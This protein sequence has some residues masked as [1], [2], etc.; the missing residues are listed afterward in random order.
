MGS[1]ETPVL[2]SKPVK[3]RW[4][5]TLKDS[6]GLGCVP[7]SLVKRKGHFATDSCLLGRAGAQKGKHQRSFLIRGCREQM[8]SP[9]PPGTALLTDVLCLLD[10]LRSSEHPVFQP[11]HLGSIIN[12]GL[13]L[14]CI[15]SF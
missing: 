13:D 14:I 9:G 7:S 15:Y 8:G 1:T 6:L 2:T 5:D 3:D 4:R 12:P 11:S 10:Q